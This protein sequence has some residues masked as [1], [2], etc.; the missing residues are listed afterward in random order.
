M[1]R[2]TTKTLQGKSLDMDELRVRNEKTQ[3]VGNK[4]RGK[5]HAHAE[6][7]IN[8]TVAT[9]TRRPSR[10][11]RRQSHKIVEDAPVM[12]SIKAAKMLVSRIIAA[13]KD[14][15]LAPEPV[16]PPKPTRPVAKGPAGPAPKPTAKPTKEVPATVKPEPPKADPVV[17]EVRAEDE[18]SDKEMDEV[19]ERIKRPS[20]LA[21]AIARA[22]EVKQ[23]PLKTPREQQ[24]GEDGVKKF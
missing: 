11:G 14:G 13:E 24:R 1:A 19:I 20:G 2:N 16:A 21:G 3:P 17:E 6:I 12:N 8:E 4:H 7:E 10:D 9:S 18:V 15:T 22:R 5:A 23:E